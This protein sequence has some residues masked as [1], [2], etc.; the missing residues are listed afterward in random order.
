MLWNLRQKYSKTLLIKG[1]PPAP[2][3][4]RNTSPLCFKAHFLTLLPPEFSATFK[5]IHGG[6][7]S[8]QSSGE[9]QI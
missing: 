8:V 7:S 5:V 6:C 1:K 4:T 3:S 2:L 9:I